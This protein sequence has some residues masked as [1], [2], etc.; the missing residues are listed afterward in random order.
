MLPVFVELCELKPLCSVT[1][2]RF[3]QSLHLFHVDFVTGEYV[4][5]FFDQIIQTLGNVELRLAHV[6]AH[7]IPALDELKFGGSGKIK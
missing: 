4:M 6:V 3:H 1:F 5:K 2:I 7:L